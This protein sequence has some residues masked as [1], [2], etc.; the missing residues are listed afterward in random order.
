MAAILAFPAIIVPETLDPINPLG[1]GTCLRSETLTSRCV[2]GL[3]T[4]M[5]LKP[6]R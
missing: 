1:K 6:L 4:L 3:V 2:Q 5:C